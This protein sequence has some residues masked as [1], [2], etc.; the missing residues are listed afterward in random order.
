MALFKRGKTWWTDFSV[1]GVRYRQSLES[2]DW[3][4]AQRLEKERIS[5]AQQGKLSP[6]SQQFARLLFSVAAD[7]FLAGRIAQL[8][9]RTVQTENERMKPLKAYFGTIP[10]TR[11]SADY[12]QQYITQL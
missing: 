7:R 6:S 5:E 3:R 8:A 11:I 10:L 1:D 12:V 9:P 2:T 4:Q